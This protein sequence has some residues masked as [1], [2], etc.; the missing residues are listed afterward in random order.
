MFTLIIYIFKENL[1]LLDYG[2]FIVVLSHVLMFISVKIT[3]TMANRCHHINN[4]YEP[5]HEGLDGGGGGSGI[6][7]S[8][9]I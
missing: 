3:I 2:L 5:T 4:P 9:K 1:F 7:Y 6:H 8:L